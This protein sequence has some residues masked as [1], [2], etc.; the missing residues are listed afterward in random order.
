M[1]TD[2]IVLRAACG[3]EIPDTQYFAKV[4]C[5]FWA[6]WKRLMILFAPGS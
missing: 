3:Y 2:I 6:G 5:G 1:L 4:S